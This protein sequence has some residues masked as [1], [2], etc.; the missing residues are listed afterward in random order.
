MTFENCNWLHAFHAGI[1]SIDELELYLPLGREEKQQL[2]T[3]I[4]QHPML[5][6]TYYISLIDKEDPNDPLRKMMVPSTDELDLSGEYDTSG[7][8]SNM[9]V[10]GL[11]HKYKQTALILSTSLCASYCRYCFRKRLVG[12]RSNEVLDNLDTIVAYIQ[13]HPKINNILVSGGDA[14]VLPT[15]TLETILNRLAALP[16]LSFIRIGSKV[17]VVLPQRITEDNRLLELLHRLSRADRRIYVIT[18]FNHPKE[19]TSQTTAAINALISANCILSNQTTLLKGVNDT[20]EVLAKLLTTLAGIGDLP[21]YVF[22]CRPVKRVQASFQLPLL[23]GL[24]I[25]EAAKSMLNGQAKRF[26]YVLSH[27]TGKIEIIGKRHNELFL[28]YHQAKNPGMTG[29]FFTV[30][31]TEHTGWLE[32]E[33]LPL[34][35]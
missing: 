33:V 11:Q 20:P 9:V 2:K 12:L 34:P 3:V 6:S 21:Y 22:Q 31:V 16:Q 30:P 27:K 1:D 7:E 28:K 18:Q 15:E 8:L 26:K 10:K 23:K 17:P 32:E 13:D 5:V 4:N 24:E 29:V 14:L 25:V 19:I 35:N